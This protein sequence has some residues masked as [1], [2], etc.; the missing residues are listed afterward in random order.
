MPIGVVPREP[1]HLEPHHDPG[2]SESDVRHQLPKSVAPSRG[3]TRLS[4][5]GVDH[6]DPLLGPAKRRRAPP[7]RVLPFRA[8]DVLEHLLH[9]RLTNVQ[10]RVTLK[11]MRLDFARFVH[12]SSGCWRFSSPSPRKGERRLSAHRWWWSN[13]AGTSAPALAS[14]SGWPRPAPMPT[15]RVVEAVRARS[16]PP[17]GADHRQRLPAA[18]RTA[19]SLSPRLRLPRCNNG[20]SPHRF[21]STQRAL[22][23]PRVNLY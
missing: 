20:R 14:R 11:V 9:R 7:K 23:R 2:A 10:V 21:F 19:R 17:A 12:G 3:C 15:C 5:V 1:R 13:S 8:L 22:D 16:S 6:D 18:S 4:L